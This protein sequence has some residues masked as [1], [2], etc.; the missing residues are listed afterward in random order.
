MSNF[1]TSAP[2]FYF[3]PPLLESQEIF[4][5]YLLLRTFFFCFYRK[6][7]LGAPEPL[8]VGTNR[9]TYDQPHQT[10][11]CLNGGSWSTENCCLIRGMIM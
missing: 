10:E 9:R 2:T 1:I 11:Q 7:P 4:R 3:S 5:Q 6:K 8:L